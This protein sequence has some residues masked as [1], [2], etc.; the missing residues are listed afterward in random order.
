MATVTNIGVFIAVCGYISLLWGFWP[1]MLFAVLPTNV[2][3]VAW[4]TGNYYMSTVLLILATHWTAMNIGTFQAIPFYVAALGSTVN[5]IPY[6]F[7]LPFLKSWPMGWIMFIPL[8]FYLFGNRFQSGLKL[9][10]EKH[11][12]I[13]IEAGKISWR[14]IFVMVKVVGYYILLNL[15]PSRLGFF[16]EYP[17]YASNDRADR[18]FWL[19]AVLIGLFAWVGFTWN[20]IGTIWWFLFIGIFSQFTTFG[21]FV[22]ERYML[23]A[24]VGFC[25]IVASYFQSNPTI[26]WIIATLWACKS[27][28]YIRAYK[29]N[30]YLFSHSISAFPG[31][32]ENY[33]NLA[34][35]YIERGQKEKAIEP[36]L[37]ALRLTTTKSEGIHTNLANC[38]SQVGYFQ[39]ALFHT[40]EA[41][42]YCADNLREGLIK[43][44]MDLKDRLEKIERNQRTLKKYGII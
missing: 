3:G 18:L 12:L 23:V 41:L 17:K 15:W 22:A 34:S 24:N 2:C 11:K 32:P 39:K 28:S 7:V 27:W 36:L 21:M 42:K 19:N 16:H 25:L 10:Q 40:Q 43:Q 4:T 33:N 31:T 5:A 38:Y 30:L 6:A 20:I 13:H 29:S 26:L 35:H 37:C 44:E 8:A 9:R 1:A 14:S